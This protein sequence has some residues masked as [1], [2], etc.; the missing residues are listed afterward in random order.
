MQIK[1]IPKFGLVL[2]F[3]ITAST[4]GFGVAKALVLPV[5]AGLGQKC[6]GFTKCG[7]QFFCSGV[8]SQDGVCVQ[9]DGSSDQCDEKLNESCI[10]NVCTLPGG[11]NA[12]DLC[13]KDSNCKSGLICGAK[14]ICEETGGTTGGTGG[15][16]GITGGTGGTGE[17]SWMGIDLTIQ[18]VFAIVNGLACWLTR[19][20]TAIMVIFLVIAGLRFMYARG[21]P[22]KY[23]SAKKNFQHV[24]IGI[25]VIMAVYV[26]IATVAN[27]VGV[28]DF[29]F[30][31]LKC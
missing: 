29:S 26:I 10:N 8:D 23:E 19:I 5:E 15:A 16:G 24:L 17:E 31:P 9:C 3:V 1:I 21:E 4:F 2:F 14:R 30:I 13:A 25:L 27:A 11:N 7:T 12:G 20:A 6:N 28:T 18:D 22:A